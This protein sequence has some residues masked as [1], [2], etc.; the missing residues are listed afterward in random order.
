MKTILDKC[1]GLPLAIVN[2]ASHLVSYNSPNSRD[3]WE[4]VCKSIGSQMESNPTLEGMNYNHL[5]HHLKGCMIYLSIFPEDSVIDKTRLLYTRWIAE[6]L[7]TGKRGLKLLE[8]AESYFDE[9]ISRNMI[10]PA[11]IS[12]DGKVE[13]CQVHDMMLEVLV[14]KSLEANFLPL[15]GRQSKGTSYDKIRRLSIHGEDRA[16]G[17]VKQAFKGEKQ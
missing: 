4:R 9:L 5:P 2:I 12:Y 6:G 8:V 10:L 13:A 7:I 14:S 17:V 1:G 16:P 11:N 3:M 15:V